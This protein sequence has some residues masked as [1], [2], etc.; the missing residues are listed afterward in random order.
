[1]SDTYGGGGALNDPMTQAIIQMLLQ[2]GGLQQQMPAWQGSMGP[3][4]LSQMTFGYDP[5]MMQ[6]S[7]LAGFIP[8]SEDEEDAGTL[9]E[10]ARQGNYLQD[11]LDLTADPVAAAM[12]G[13]GGFAGDSFAP[14]VSR[15]LIPRPNTDRFNQWLQQPDSWEGMI[16]S[17]VAQGRSPRSAIIELR[18]IME[19]ADADAEANGDNADQQLQ[20]QAAQIRRMLPPAWQS[21]DALEPLTGA[22]AIDWQQAFDDADDL[23]KPYLEEQET[24]PGPVGEQRN[25]F[26]DIISS[27]GE[28]VVGPDGQL[29]RET[30]EES[31][32]AEKYRELGIPLPTETYDAGDLLGAQ[33]QQAEQTYLNDVP[34]LD[35]TYRQLMQDYERGMQNATGANLS[36]AD[37]FRMDQQAAMGR[38]AGGR[39]PTAAVTPKAQPEPQGGGGFGSL[40]ADADAGVVGSWQR[41][42]GPAIE[43]NRA[44]METTGV[45]GVWGTTPAALQAG[46]GLA[47]DWW[48]VGWQNAGDRA[49]RPGISTILGD[50]TQ[51]NPAVGAIADT[52]VD[53]AAL[54]AGRVDTGRNWLAQMIDNWGGGLAAGASNIFGGGNDIE[55]QLT[56]QAA[57]GQ[58]YSP[59]GAQDPNAGLTL[60]QQQAQVAANPAL[61]TPAWQEIL[62]RSMQNGQT[63]GTPLPPLNTDDLAAIFTRGQGGVGGGQAGG[64]GGP[65]T[66][67]DLVGAPGAQP[68]NTV[69][70]GAIFDAQGRLLG[71]EPGAGTVD[72]ANAVQGA[73]N[74]S[75]RTG[76][77][78]SE[79]AP[80]NRQLTQQMILQI[81]GQQPRPSGYEHNGAQFDAQG[82]LIGY[83]TNNTST[84]TGAEPSE[85]V[86][87]TSRNTSG[88]TGP[89]PSEQ[90]RS[91]TDLIWP[92][93][94]QRQTPAPQETQEMLRMLFPGTQSRPRSLR[95][96]SKGGGGEPAQRTGK[97]NLTFGTHRA[98]PVDTY[99][100]TEAG[101]ARR[102]RTQANAARSRANS[103]SQ[104]VYNED[105]WRARGYAEA[106][107]RMGVTP[108]SVA[109]ANRTGG[110][111][112]MFGRK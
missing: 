111:N 32:L 21:N 44:R 70:N 43:E 28:I 38:G 18:E 26:G 5:T 9:E 33:W 23:I 61:Q 58:Q 108:T 25:E 84:R 78:P 42:I 8:P 13:G 22:Q 107:Q 85:G 55:N 103:D 64:Q 40:W 20:Q 82:R 73:P 99:R 94:R 14:T 19:N 96:G 105:Y 65:R 2:G 27:G 10:A 86:K 12:F 60:A 24:Q 45:P 81:L 95:G 106:L 3:D 98:G 29:Y 39:A 67:E 83:D 46:A 52:V 49:G 7:S 72:W 104:A 41:M 71:Y 48:D 79:G 16:A 69:H 53:A 77:E 76:P 56:S 35:D 15:E 89:E 100:L 47:R 109:L 62:Q 31:P 30:T 88:R 93:G 101:K 6:Q 97:Q 17:R 34:A 59:G 75:G 50:P 74:T 51:T 11:F 36:Q 80:A 102:S 68:A 57:G 90:T 63:A 87:R 66:I 37:V 54:D 112:Q 4:I 92:G 110:L 91:L 1:M